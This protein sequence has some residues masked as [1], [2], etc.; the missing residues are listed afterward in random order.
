MKQLMMTALTL[1]VGICIVMAQPINTP[2]LE[3][4]LA[5]AKELEDKNDHLQALE[6][7]EKAYEDSEDRSLL[8][9]IAMLAIQV[10]DYRKA[11][12]RLRSVL[13][14]DEGLYPDAKY[15]YGKMLKMNEKYDDAILELRDFIVETGDPKLKKLAQLELQGA[16]M[17]K[18]MP[19]AAGFEIESTGK[20]INNKQ[21]QYS[22][23]LVGETQLFYAGFDSD[24][25][26]TIDED[27]DEYH[28]KIYEAQRG[29][30]G[31]GKPTALGTKINRE[32]FHNSNVHVTPDGQR[33]Y[34][35]RALL[36]GNILQESKIM[37]SF[38]GSG[39]WE[40]A[41]EVEGVNSDS[42][43]KHPA[44][45]E[46]FGK[47]VLFF[48]SN[49]AGG[50]GGFDLYYAPSNGDGTFGLPVNLKELNTPSDESSPFF[51]EGT[52]YFS[53]DGYPTMGGKD[54]FYSL[55]DGTN[56]SDPTNMGKG[57]NSSVDDL[58][59]SLN[60]DGY[61]GVLV[62]NRPDK[63]TRSVGSRTCC[64]DIFEFVIPKI[65]AAIVVGTFTEE[66]KP[67]KGASVSIE[68]VEL[69]D[70]FSQTN[71]EGNVFNFPL[72]VEKSYKL[73]ASAPGY[74]PDSVEV[75]T[76]GIE[77]TTSY[78]HRFYLTKMPPPPPPEPEFDTIYS[79]QAIELSNVYFIFNEV[80]FIDGAEEDLE[81]I[82]ELMTDYPEMKIELRSHTDARGDDAYNENLS[83]GRAEAT[84]RWLIRKGITRARM[85]A[86]GYGETVPKTVTERNAQEFDFLDEGDVL[87]ES[88][89]DSLETTEQQEAAH[90][91]N[92]RTEFQILE[93]PKSIQVK[94][95]RLRK[96]VGAGGPKAVEPRL[97]VRR[98]SQNVITPHRLSSLYG[99]KD[100]TGF[101]MMHFKERVV[102]FGI[103]KKGEKRKH[104]YEFT[105]LGDT[106]MEIDF[107]D[108]CDCTEVDY[109]RL[110]VAP[111]ESGKISVVFDSKDKDEAETISVDI[112]LKQVDPANDLNIFET[113]QYVFD[114]EK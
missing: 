42:I 46:L 51:R 79:E 37:I 86:K 5:V 101:P 66:K 85:E 91:L 60:G 49:M 30:K 100:L 3:K 41:E 63:G 38:K 4:T 111:G 83:Q 76:L 103:V 44:I 15:Y 31:W 113:V 84:R 35:T 56:W 112:F 105:N 93:G 19:P 109:P 40:G 39:G 36:S 16:E 74:F 26:I 80:K 99:K 89:I 106:T 90:Q 27:S 88:Y 57:I 81:L 2:T 67:L 64:N 97:P 23:S 69:E 18:G 82:Y 102:D 96:K 75:N 25:L 1:L 78:E 50:E 48:V 77:E 45:G 70:P 29:E 71:A 87:T 54:V 68:E 13:R 58:Y 14:R 47:E 59:F 9:P 10:K 34:F 33:M 61:Q 65:T 52:L 11:E 114:I 72:A 32:G 17:A 107:V 24:D 12:R 108:H 104:V 55:W 53:T 20:E 7:Y 21:G 8:Y 73:V 43:S 94:R 95:T 110:P 28:A 98:T 62:S 6:W 92:R 22:P